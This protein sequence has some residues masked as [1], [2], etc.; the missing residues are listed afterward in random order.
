[1]KTDIF[2]KKRKTRNQKPLLTTEAR[3]TR[4]K[5]RKNTDI[6]HRKDAK[7]AEEDFLG[8]KGSNL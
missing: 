3:R 6:L 5:K 1:M 7:N 2:N 8:N 4:S